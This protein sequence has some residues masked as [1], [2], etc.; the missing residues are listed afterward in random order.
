MCRWYLAENTDSNV[1]SEASAHNVLE[2]NKVY[3]SEI[4]PEVIQAKIV[5]RL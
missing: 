5:E 4:G 3:G 1:D 2:E